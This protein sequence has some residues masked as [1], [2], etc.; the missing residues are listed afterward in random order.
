MKNSWHTII[1]SFQVYNIVIWYLHILWNDHHHKSSNHP[2]AKLLQ[3]YWPYSLYPW[4]VHFINGPLIPLYLFPSPSHPS[5]LWQGP[6][7]SL[8]LWVLLF[9]FFVR[10]VFQFLQI[11]EITWYLSFF[12]VS[13]SSC[14]NWQDFILSYGLN[15]PLCIYT[16]SLLS[17]HL[18]VKTQLASKNW[19]L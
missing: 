16:T 6:V 19:L 7:Y 5:P 17:I 2:H 4:P 9:Y 1:W 14:C 11:N 13:F 12:D 15:I 8:C 3:Y 10:L 18:L